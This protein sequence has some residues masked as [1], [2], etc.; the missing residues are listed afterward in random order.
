MFDK[1]TK[2]E[3]ENV[4]LKDYLEKQQKNYQDNV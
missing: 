3:S 1:E 2:K 4:S